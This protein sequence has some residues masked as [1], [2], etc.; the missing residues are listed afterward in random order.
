MRIPGEL[1]RSDLEQFL[2]DLERRLAGRET[3]P[4]ADAEDV[5]VDGNGGVAEGR[6][7]HDVGRLAPDAGQRLERRPVLGDHAAMPLDQQ[8]TGGDDVPR[9]GAEQADGLD[10]FGKAFLAERQHRLWGRRDRKEP[11]RRLV[12]PDIGRLR[13]ED[14][15]D[16]QLERRRVFEF[17]GRRRVGCRQAGIEFGNL[18]LVHGAGGAG[19]VRSD[20]FD[21]ARFYL[22]RTL[23][24]AQRKKGVER[25]DCR[26]NLH[27]VAA[28]VARR[29]DNH[30]K[31]TVYRSG[32]DSCS[33]LP[34][35]KGTMF[36][37]V[38]LDRPNA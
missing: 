17:G 33:T 34:R 13:R 2:L 14:D 20:W 32:C 9:L 8:A 29:T 19:G 4:V 26:K 22:T 6:V 25:R 21:G 15:G 11:R 31:S 7:E 18:V 5:G 35:D 28:P 24:V 37:G 38:L 36:A 27:Q 1:R 12:D 3:G 23:R 30:E 16:Q 10:K